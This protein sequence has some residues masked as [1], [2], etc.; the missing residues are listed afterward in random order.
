MPEAGGA[1]VRISVILCT[2]NR[3]LYLR[4]ALESI[5]ASVLPDLVEWEVLVVDNNSGDKTREMANEFAVRYPWCFRYIFEPRQGKS[6][7][8]NTGIRESKGDVLAFVD[9]DVT[10]GPTWLRNLTLP[11]H[12]KTWAGVGGRTLMANPF[13]PPP[14]LTLGAPYYLGGI[15]CAMFDLGDKSCELHDPPYGAN[16]AFRRVMFEKYGSFRTDLG[17]SPDREI[18]RPNEDTEFGRRLMAAGERLFYEPSAIV[19]HPVPQNRLRKEY[20]LDWWFDYG[21]AMVREWGRKPDVWGIPRPYL[22]ILKMSTIGIAP[23]L[24][25]WITTMDQ[26]ERFARKC[27][28]WMAAGVIREFY[29]VARSETKIPEGHEIAENPKAHV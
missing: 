16:M 11:L 10:V 14:W 20:F 8:L 27:W 22:S 19:Y 3:C 4:K 1:V 7:A 6:H 21:R 5:A 13:S 26:Q 23:R 17:P 25:S 2:Y 29:R 24:I 15:L 9:D 28:V 18:P 12:D